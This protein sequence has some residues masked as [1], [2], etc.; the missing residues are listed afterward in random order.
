MHE[1]ALADALLEQVRRHTPEGQHAVLV[2]I[3]AGPLQS[4]DPEAFKM[5]WQAVTTETELEGC[6]MDLAS[7]PY[8]LSCPKCGRR[9]TA[10][11]PFDACACG[12]DAISISGAAGGNELRLISM[13]VEPLEAANTYL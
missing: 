9:W 12:N 10:E 4:I 11:D 5:A 6:A 13:E 7:L 3:E 1:M 8:S 2:R